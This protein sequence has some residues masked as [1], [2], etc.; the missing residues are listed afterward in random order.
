MGLM[1]Y[2]SRALII[3]GGYDMYGPSAFWRLRRN[4]VQVKTNGAETDKVPKPLLVNN[5]FSK[6]RHSSEN[7]TCFQSSEVQ[8]RLSRDHE[9]R[10]CLCRGNK[11]CPRNGLR[12]RIPC[13][14]KIRLIWVSLHRKT[15]AVSVAVVKGA[16]K[17]VLTILLVVLSVSFWF[18]GRGRS[19]KVP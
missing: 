3:L 9:R 1:L 15:L 13:F 4:L 12:Q 17:W 8:F 14:L 19:F 11:I 16:F 7:K 18:P 5:L 10:F 2:Y 6:N